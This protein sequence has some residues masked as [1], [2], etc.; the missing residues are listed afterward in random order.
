MTH[1]LL[2]IK[3]IACYKNSWARKTHAWLYMH[4]SQARLTTAK[5]DEWTIRKS[6]YAKHSWSHNSYTR[7]ASLTPVIYEIEFKTLSIIFKGLHGKAPSYIQ[8]IIVPSKIRNIP[9]DPM[10]PEDSKIQTRYFWQACICG[11]WASGM[12][13]LAKRDKVMWWNWSIPANLKNR[14]VKFVNESNLI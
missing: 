2:S 9:W 10:C 4:L 5:F 8:E 1:E 13:L 6:T 11:V 14:F 7:Y 12:E 3:C